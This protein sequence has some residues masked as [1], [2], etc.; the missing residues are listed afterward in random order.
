MLLQIADILSREECVA[1]IEALSNSRF[2]RDGKSTAKGR[3]R[4]VK[5]NL[6]ADAAAAEVKGAIKKIEMALRANP[7]F[8]AASQP[9]QFA[10]I[11]LNRYGPGMG[12]GAHVDAPFIEGVRS[13]L[14]FTVFLSDP[15]D[16]EGGALI[17]D[18]AGHEDEIRGGAGSV[19][20]Y[21]STAVHR[22]DE[23]ATGERFACIG[24]VKSRIRSGDHRSILF[25]LE[26]A[27]AE[28]QNTS[29]PKELR[30]RMA[31]VRNNLLR[32]F[33]E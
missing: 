12:Y 28:L 32:T 14:S 31:N 3:A 26:T 21:P 27:I 19:V 11:I 16:Y 4:E 9:A 23:V 15:A 8:C 10:R 33:G 13:D 24:W 22:V 29:A 30:D 7:V 17:I 18:N 25:D 1:I 5:S 6:Q 20:L 2:W